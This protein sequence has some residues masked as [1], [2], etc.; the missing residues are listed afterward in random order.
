MGAPLGNK[1]ASFKNRRF[2]QAI[3]KALKQYE[4]PELKIEAGQALDHIGMKLVTK[5]V[6][7]D[8]ED[9]KFAMTTIGD[10]LEGK[11]PVALQV[12]GGLGL[13]QME[14]DALLGLFYELS[15]ITD[16]GAGALESGSGPESNA[17]DQSGTD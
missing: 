2:T 14:G 10:R 8:R 16:S 3:D 9:F 7:G 6:E 1:N 5:A 12:T 17:D 4:N 15:N 13:A 11:A